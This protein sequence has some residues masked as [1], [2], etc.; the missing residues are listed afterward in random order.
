[1]IGDQIR[2]LSQ[3]Q[4]RELFTELGGELGAGDHGGRAAGG[5]DI[6]LKGVEALMVLCHVDTVD[7]DMSIREYKKEE[8]FREYSNT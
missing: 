4:L 3:E 6:M 1:M 5:G 7:E 2:G 8:V